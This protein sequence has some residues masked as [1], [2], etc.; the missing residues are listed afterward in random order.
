MAEP[1]NHILKDRNKTFF[2][3]NWF[4][5]VFVTGMESSLAYE[6]FLL[7]GAFLTS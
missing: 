5:H 2:F 7:D 3:I 1:F 4:S 6:Y